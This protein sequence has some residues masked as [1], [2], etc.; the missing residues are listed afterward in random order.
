MKHLKICALS[1]IALFPVKGY[2]YDS[3]FTLSFE[4]PTGSEGWTQAGGNTVIVTGDHTPADTPPLSPTPDTAPGFNGTDWLRIGSDVQA[5]GVSTAFYDGRAG[6]SSATALDFVA[7]VDAYIS[8]NF[9]NR[10]QVA[11]HGRAN[12][13]FS[14]PQVF[15]SHNTPGFDN[16][17]GWRGSGITAAYNGFGTGAET[18]S[19]WVRFKI[20]LIGA[21][22]TFEVDRDLDGTYDLNSGPIAIA[23]AGQDAGTVG[24]LSVINDPTSG[25]AI[26]NI[27]GYF[28]NLTYAPVPSSVS[29]WSMY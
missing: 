29:D 20:T 6:G 9:A 24:V 25:V 12:G 19:R 4:E 23:A 14:P 8:T 5:N 16:G 17:Y 7:T 26:P 13:E 18:S 22:A 21:T 10:Y 11:L 2:G 27:Y 3:S 15:Y 1:A 28:D